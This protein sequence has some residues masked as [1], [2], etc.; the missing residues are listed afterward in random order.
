MVKVICMQYIL[1]YRARKGTLLKIYPRNPGVVLSTTHVMCPKM[2][3]IVLVSLVAPIAQQ[4]LQSPC[5]TDQL[6]MDLNSRMIFDFMLISFVS[7]NTFKTSAM[8][9]FICNY[10]CCRQL[11]LG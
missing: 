8:L 5:L 9:S 2:L 10:W 7:I 3:N 4:G 6:V 11:E 1:N